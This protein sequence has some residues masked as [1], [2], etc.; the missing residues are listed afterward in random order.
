MTITAPN[1]VGSRRGSTAGNWLDYRTVWRWHFYAGLFA[2]PFI[3]FLSIT[4]SLYLFR[5][6]VEA[7]LDLPYDNMPTAQSAEPSAVVG[8]AL[9][10]N[11]GWMLRA[12]QLPRTPQ[13][14]AQIILS[15][16]GVEQRLY[17]DRSN[18]KTLYKVG[19]EERPMRRIFW[20]HGELLAGNRGSNLVELAASW[21]I[22]MI[23]TGLYLWWPR[24]TTGFGGI[25]YPRL[26]RG[27]RTTLRD[28]HGVTG[29]WVS[30]FALGFLLSGLPWANNWGH[31]LK[32]VRRIT[33]STPISQDWTTGSTDERRLRQARDAIAAGA[34]SR[35]TMPGMDHAM[36]GMA[37]PT[38]ADSVGDRFGPL[39][40][41]DR[42]F[43]TAATLDLK[44]PVTLS[45]PA[46]RGGPWTAASQTQDRPLRATVRLD[47]KSGMVISRTN[48]NQLHW[49]DR[50]VGY[51]TAAHEGQLFG[52]FN[53]LLNLSLAV[54]LTTV[55]VTAVLMWWRRRSPGVLGAPAALQPVHGSW[56]LA[57]TIAALGALLPEFLASLVVVLVCERLVLRRIP[58]VRN[59]LALS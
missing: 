5:P 25:L 13:S 56:M 19:E 50:L 9:K 40:G 11:P 1:E 58:G 20:L 2:I 59:W 41:L 32:S 35:D 39:E 34:V 29:M 38:S 51:T 47:S 36:H 16:D 44:P 15:R 33:G 45:P 52:W 18:L 3:I 28:L 30:I 43:R 10:E 37:M 49:L 12:Y 14:A 23:V 55:S 22:I 54:S 48:F 24:G 6:Q 4:G 53:Q 31:Y 8:A 26:S 57:V 17:I 21:S 42:V 7:W 27:G 46:K